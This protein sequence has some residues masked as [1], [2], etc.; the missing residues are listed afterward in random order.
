[1]FCQTQEDFDEQFIRNLTY[2]MGH[3]S[4]KR[5]NSVSVVITNLLQEARQVFVEFLEDE[6]KEK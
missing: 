1:M 4:R 2:S 6:K 3:V 5:F